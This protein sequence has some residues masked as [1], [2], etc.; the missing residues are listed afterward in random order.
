[1]NGVHMEDTAALLCIPL[2]TKREEISTFNTGTPSDIFVDC[3][4][5]ETLKEKFE[6]R[7]PWMAQQLLEQ[8]DSKVYFEYIFPTKRYQALATIFATTTLSGYST[9]PTFMESPKASLAFLMNIAGLNSQERNRFFNNMSQSDLYKAFTDNK[10]SDARGMECFDL[11]FS[12]E[13]LE[14]FMSMLLEAIKEFPSLLFR[15]IA[16][17]VD[18]A[19][20]EMKLHYQNCEISDLTFGAI[21]TKSADKL[22]RLQPDGTKSLRGGLQFRTDR[23]KDGKYSPLVSTF[24]RDIVYSVDQLLSLTPNTGPMKYTMRHFV[25]Y[26][27][28]GPLSLFDGAFQFSI[29]CVEKANFEWDPSGTLNAGRY[30]HPISPLTAIALAM[31]ELKGDKKLREISGKCS[32]DGGNIIAPYS[33]GSLE[34]P[35]LKCNDV[36]PAAFGDKIPNPDD[37]K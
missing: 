18:P 29:P 25:N 22:D 19:Y 5:L 27:Y 8:E 26:L 2:V 10:V 33:R 4:D 30:G 24:S 13:F 21:N 15:G 12:T 9:M 23:K 37:F 6:Q 14:D 17:V 20:K 31:P 32:I 28:K 7:A 11:P 16:S 1:M 36:P 35:E 34:N 3:Y